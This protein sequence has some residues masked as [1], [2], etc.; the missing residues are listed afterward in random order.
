MI[1]KDLKELR[2]CMVDIL[3]DLIPVHS[4]HRVIEYIDKLQELDLLP[5]TKELLCN[6]EIRQVLIKNKIVRSYEVVDWLKQKRDEYLDL[7][8]YIERDKDWKTKH[9]IA[10]E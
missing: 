10:T 2:E 6:K 8:E 4:Y 9:N 1:F 7:M 3:S 5:E